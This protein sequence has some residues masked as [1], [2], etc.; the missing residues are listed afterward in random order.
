MNWWPA[1]LISMTHI[2]CLLIVSG[3]VAD[4]LIMI[5]TIEPSRAVCNSASGQIV[6]I[7]GKQQVNGR[8]AAGQMFS[9][10]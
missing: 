10:V 2:G 6:S 5:Y 7:G 3:A 4:S 9:S 1:K 8:Q